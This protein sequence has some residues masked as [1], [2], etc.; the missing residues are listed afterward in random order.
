[1]LVLLGL[2]LLVHQPVYLMTQFL[3]ARAQQREIARVLVLAGAANVVLSVTL[4]AT[5]GLWA[6]P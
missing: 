5:V 6:S 3:I 4:A 2:V 1:M